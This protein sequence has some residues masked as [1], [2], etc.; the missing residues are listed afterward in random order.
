MRSNMRARGMPSPLITAILR[1]I[2]RTIGPPLDTF[3]PITTIARVRVPVLLVHGGRDEVVP[4]ADAT[5]LAEA[6]AG[7]ARLLVV[8]EADHVSLEAFL[9]AAPAVTSFIQDAARSCPDDG[10]RAG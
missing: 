9:L 1:E 4:P 5:L 7:R 3:A 2:E 8:P 10:P 6:S